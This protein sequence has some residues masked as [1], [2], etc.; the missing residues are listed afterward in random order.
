[1]DFDDLISIANWLLKQEC[2][3]E[4]KWLIVDEFQD[5]NAEQIQFLN[6]LSA[7]DSSFFAVGD[8]NQSI[9][10]WR[11]SS[12]Q[13][14]ESYVADT[15]CCLMRLPLNYRTSGQILSA[16]ACLLNQE[17]NELQATRTAGSMLRLV[18][19]FDDS[20][21]AFYYA[22]QFEELHKQ[23]T[24][25]EQIAILFRTR[26]QI[27]LFE[28]IFRK[29]G[30]PFEVIS[31]INLKD[32]PALFW[33]K[34]ILLVGLQPNDLD[35]ILSVFTSSDFAC[36][37]NG[38]ALLTAFAKFSQEKIFNNKL[39][40]FTAFLNFKYPKEEAHLKLANALLAFR[41]RLVNV[42]NGLDLFAYFNFDQWLKPTSVH[43][44][45]YV[46]QVKQA[47]LE[48]ELYVQN[49]NFESDEEAYQLAMSMV[50]LEGHFQI[51]T[52]LKKTQNGVRLL[53]IHAA[54][55]LEFDH[56][57][58][59]GANSGLIPLQR[60]K[61]GPQHLQEEKR[62]LFVALT[63]A[64]NHMEIAWHSQ[65]SA[66]N[67]EEGPSYF[68][69]AIPSSLIERVEAAKPEIA[70]PKQ[71]EPQETKDSPWQKEMKI[72]H[73]K[74]GKGIVISSTAK[75]IICDFGKF[76]EKSFAPHWAALKKL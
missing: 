12:D 10:A 1:M 2:S 43:Y 3:L 8:P 7:K 67:A 25:W 49:Q 35:S 16:A 44:K 51:N 33:L 36:L 66:W 23:G 75:E 46:N 32:Y 47:L 56:V 40:A 54:K 42:E 61:A 11:G 63:R 74:Y 53:T 5:C 37:K 55:G 62:L 60:K 58:L 9:Y 69:N 71:V 18:N 65:S 64:K 70:I 20:Q 31:K 29:E 21:E 17:Q 6:Y 50:N 57:Y 28:S 4:A 24:P 27:G 72:S 68:L 13:I 45:D 22:K 59:S 26:Q 34:K 76:G 30:I 48:L 52:G 41:D 19:H 39:E 14:F 73:P 38:K 15:N